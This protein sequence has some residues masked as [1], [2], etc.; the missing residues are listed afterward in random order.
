VLEQAVEYGMIELNPALGER[1]RLRTTLP[2]RSYLHTDPKPA[3][4][5][6]A[7]AMGRDDRQLQELRAIV[8]GTDWAAIGQQVC[9]L[10]TLRGSRRAWR[11]TKKPY[12]SGAFRSGRGGFRTCDLSHVKRLGGSVRSPGNTGGAGDHGCPTRDRVC[13]DMRGCMR[14]AAQESELCHFVLGTLR[15]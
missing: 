4:A 2:A 14:I 5:I 8:E 3:L 10:R 7:Q 11:R 13:V 1:R 15:G 12:L 6:Y 9:L